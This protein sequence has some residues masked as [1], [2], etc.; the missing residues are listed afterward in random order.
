MKINSIRFKTSIF[1]SGILLAIL[2]LF[3][4]YLYATIHHILYQEVRQGLA[5]KAGQID[6]F[7]DAYADI[8]TKDNLMND[9][10]SASD[11]NAAPKWIINHLWEQDSKSLGL[12][13]DYFRIL[14]PRGRVRLRSDN[15]TNNI[16]SIFAPQFP[17]HAD[18]IT[19]NHFQMNN[20]LYYGISYPFRFS[21][22]NSFVLQL[23]TP[24]D[25][26]QQILSQSVLFMALGIVSILLITVFMGSFLTRRILKPV[27]EVTLTA[28]NIS[29]KNLHLRIPH[30]KLDHEM[31]ELVNSFN[32]M[33]DR[34]EGSFAHIND[35]SSHVAH[36]LKTP[37][38]IIKTEMELALSKDNPPQEDKRVMKIAL[39]E[40]DRLVRTIKD[41]L[42]LAK[43]EYKLNI[44]K[45][46]EVEIIDFLRDIHQHSQI[47]AEEKNINIELKLPDYPVFLDGDTVHL[48]RIF[49]NLLHNAIKFTPTNGSI[50]ILAQV[51]DKQVVIRIKD[52]GIGIADTDKPHIFEKF[53]RVQRPDHEDVG[54]SGLG[55]CMAKTVA[56]SH[57][58]DITFESQLNKGTTFIVTLPITHLQRVFTQI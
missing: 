25:S 46:D 3:S 12:N 44:F 23:A 42:L 17:V 45:M 55:L 19:F 14:S 32:R 37:L 49:F 36:E 4:V 51:Q 47:L 48:R 54:G 50:E 57:G 18:Q 52:T 38:A 13:N 30:E 40:I 33:I 29:Q 31:E 7:I 11:E 39:G 58:G 34:L 21:N 27:S 8:A 22:R 28:N 35:F 1:Y 24:V 53:F 15:M 10:L 43:L 41:L 9:Y 26:V 6:A 2:G 16:E 56:R 20:S 5:L